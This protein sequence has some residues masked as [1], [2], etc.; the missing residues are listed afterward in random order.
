[1]SVS[2]PE[3]ACRD[4]GFG[5][6]YPLGETALLALE[7]Y[8]RALLQ[9]EAAEALRG[10]GEAAPVTGVHVCRPSRAFDDA[11]LADLEGFAQEMATRAGSGT[12]L[13]WS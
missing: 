6:A 5:A 2:R 1:M 12:G 10:D 8:A 3:P 13:G 7:D 11:V 9:S 4:L